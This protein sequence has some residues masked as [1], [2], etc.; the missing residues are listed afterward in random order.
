MKKKRRKEQAGAKGKRAVIVSKILRKEYPDEQPALHY[1]NPFQLLIAVILSA[2]CTDVRVNLVTPQLFAEYAT[3]DQFAKADVHRLESLIHSTGFYHNKA[4]NIIG[5]ATSLLERHS[6]N[7]PQ[8]LDE[9]VRLPG[10]GR[11]TANVVLGAAFGKIEGVVVDTHVIR[12]SNRLGFTNEQD[13]V[14]VEQ[15]LIPLIPKRD[16]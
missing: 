2:Q 1:S 15:D 3:P 11:K 4:K 9:L 13:A 5:C 14:K 16:W 12:L 7:V 8:T 6:G 10:V